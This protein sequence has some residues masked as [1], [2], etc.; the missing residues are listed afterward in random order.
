MSVTCGS[1]V[2]MLEVDEEEPHNMRSNFFNF[3]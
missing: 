2:A 1:E 3:D